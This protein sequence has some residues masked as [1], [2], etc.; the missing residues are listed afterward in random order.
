VT[1]IEELVHRVTNA[2]H[3]ILA[4]SLGAEQRGEWTIHDRSEMLSQIADAERALTFARRKVFMADPDAAA[5]VD[6]MRTLTS[7]M[8]SY[9]GCQVHLS[10][11]ARC[12]EPGAGTA[13]ISGR[14]T[15]MCIQ[16]LDKHN[17][18]NVIP[19]RRKHV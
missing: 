5:Y 16:H 15:V 6:S 1:T 4:L 12:P 17:H 19:I 2:T 14:D 11:G 9:G 10:G 8:G 3:C 7:H 13:Q 18:G